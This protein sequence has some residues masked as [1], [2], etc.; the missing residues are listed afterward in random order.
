V[1]TLFATFGETATWYAGGT[2][3][4]IAVSIILSRADVVA[5]FMTAGFA[6][7]PGAQIGALV[8][9]MRASE[10]P[11]PA[12]GDRLSVAGKIYTV[13]EVELDGERLVWQLAL[14]PAVQ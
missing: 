9:A 6:A 3:P 4:G 10:A 11:K 8:A 1:A 14:G 2:A 5:E 12:R 13:T 7:A